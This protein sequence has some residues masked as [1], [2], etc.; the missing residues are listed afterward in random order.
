MQSFFR[1]FRSSPIVGGLIYQGGNTKYEVVS[2]MSEK[3]LEAVNNV[4][5]KGT[6][7]IRP[8]IKQLHIFV[9]MC[10]VFKQ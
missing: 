3:M 5:A 8:C 2:K 10:E 1:C 4:K 6:D 9:I 7:G